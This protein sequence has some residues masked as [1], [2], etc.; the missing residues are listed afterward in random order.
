[1][2]ITLWNSSLVIIILCVKTQV[3]VWTNPSWYQ[4]QYKKILSLTSELFSL[5]EFHT[6][7]QFIL[8][9]LERTSVKLCLLDPSESL[10]LWTHRIPVLSISW[11]S[12]TERLFLNCYTGLFYSYEIRKSRPSDD[13]VLGDLIFAS[14][15]PQILR[16][17]AY[18]YC[19]NN[20]KECLI[21][22]RFLKLCGFSKQNGL[23][24]LRG[25]YLNCL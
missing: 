8:I 14:K 11:Q 13:T 7:M 22:S 12:H 25:L 1:M 16:T 18:H 2:K 4:I 10:Y 15:W 9:T 17:T 23:F 5:S 24:L 20:H 3:R 19:S 21:M 6:C